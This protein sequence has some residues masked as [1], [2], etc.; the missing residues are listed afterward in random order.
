MPTCTYASVR[1]ARKEDGT[2][3]LCMLSDLAAW[4]GSPLPPRLGPSALDKDVFGDNPKLHVF[5][6][7]DRSGQLVGFISYY[8]N[9]SSWEGSRGIHVG[10]L[11]VSTVHRGQN[12]GTALL[13][14]VTSSNEG[15]RV[16]V[17]VV[18][19]NSAR[20]FYQHHGFQEQPQWILYRKKP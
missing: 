8:E 9:Y 14:H 18:R 5:V 1:R 20:F 6:A 13:N 12:I 16:D 4:E 11:W 17:F 15:R 2:A 3:I 19:D 10:D 7:E